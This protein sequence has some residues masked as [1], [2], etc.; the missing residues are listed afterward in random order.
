MPE[1][2]IMIFATFISQTDIGI[3]TLFGS[4]GYNELVVIGKTDLFLCY[5]LLFLSCNFSYSFFRVYHCFLAP[6]SFFFQL[7]CL[8]I[9][10]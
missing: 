2:F 7:Q 6:F 5:A 10:A 8:L 3:S 1:L 9:F 4:A